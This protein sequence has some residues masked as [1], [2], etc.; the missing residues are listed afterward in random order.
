MYDWDGIDNEDG[1]V[2]LASNRDTDMLD[3][4]AKDAALICAARNALVPLLDA[5]DRLEREADEADSY[6]LSDSEE[7][8]RQRATAAEAECERLRARVGEL[9][10]VIEEKDMRIEELRRDL[11][12]EI[13][14][15]PRDEAEYDND[16]HLIAFG[17]E[18][19]ATLETALRFMDREGCTWETCVD[20]DWERM[21]FA[22]IAHAALR[23][24]LG[25]G[26]EGEP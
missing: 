24:G 2:V 23:G 12:Q 21:C 3:L 10:G 8:Q 13:E 16:Q 26:R 9:T 6:S 4:H 22:C 1:T 11:D 20:G 14:D 17:A 18:R 19:I 5:L 25:T 15:R 7:R